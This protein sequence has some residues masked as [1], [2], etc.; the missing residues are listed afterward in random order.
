L[1]TSYT[2]AQDATPLADTT[3]AISLKGLVKGTY[4]VSLTVE[5]D[6]GQ[7]TT[8]TIK[9]I[10]REP[11]PIVN[12]PDIFSPDNNN[13]NDFWKIDNADLLNGCEISIYNRQGQKVFFSSQGYP[14]PLDGGWNGTYNGQPLPDGAY[15]YI[16]RCDQGKKQTGSVTIVRSKQ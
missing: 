15:F 12:T 13:Q 9:I 16:F 8:E 14:F 4:E 2:W 11:N 1:I 10:V 6:L 3:A 7:T 5:D